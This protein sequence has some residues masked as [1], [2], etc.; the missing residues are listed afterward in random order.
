MHLPLLVLLCKKLPLDLVLT[1]VVFRAGNEHQVPHLLGWS[2]PGGQGGGGARGVQRR[3]RYDGG[4]RVRWVLRLWLSFLPSFQNARD[5]LICQSAQLWGRRSCV[6]WWQWCK[7]KSQS[8][9]KFCL[10]GVFSWDCKYRCFTVTTS[11]GGTK[12]CSNMCW[13]IA[14]TTPMQRCQL[15][16]AAISSLSE[17]KGSRRESR[18]DIFLTI[19]DSFLQFLLFSTIL[20]R[21][22]MMTSE[23][24]LRRSSQPQ[25]TS[26]KLSA[27]RMSRGFHNCHE[28]FAQA[29]WYLCPLHWKLF[30]SKA[31]W[32][33]LPMAVAQPLLQFLSQVWMNLASSP[34]IIDTTPKKLCERCHHLCDQRKDQGGGAGK[35]W[36]KVQIQDE[37]CGQVWT[38]CEVLGHLQEAGE[39][40]EDESHVRWTFQLGLEKQANVRKQQSVHTWYLHRATSV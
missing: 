27:V 1:V 31:S 7:Q 9:S 6:C 10:H 8:K 29:S 16:S 30:F 13:T 39:L 33:L 20:G 23:R 14:R 5:P 18:E 32:Y 37:R 35:R 25:S 34:L 3:V 38:Q 4:Q 26:R 17:E 15:P 12:M 2:Q 40:Q 21:W 11:L 22:M 36:R 28:E 19:F 24:T